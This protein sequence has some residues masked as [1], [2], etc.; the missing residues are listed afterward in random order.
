[1]DQN[2]LLATFAIKILQKKTTLQDMSKFIQT[3]CHLFVVVVHMR[4]KLKEIYTSIAKSNTFVF[5][6]V[7]AGF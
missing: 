6:Q 3:K 4:P 7:S 1:M 5:D 2:L